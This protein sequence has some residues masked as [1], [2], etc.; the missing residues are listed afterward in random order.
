V[1]HLGVGLIVT[2]GKGQDLY[3][4]LLHS[5]G[6]GASAAGRDSGQI[7]KLIE[8]KVSYDHDRVY[9]REACRPW[10]AL[11]LSAEEKRGTED[12]I[13]LERLAEAAAERAHTRFIVSDDP[14]EVLEQI[15][16]YVEL[17]FTELVFHFPGEDQERALRQFADD[18][19]PLIRDR[20]S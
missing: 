12:P 3:H 14:E 1:G 7:A 8:V 16:F 15:A 6:E 13:E 11:A 10:A 5:L 4:T 18:V 20:W 9:A 2:S 19:Q 17:G